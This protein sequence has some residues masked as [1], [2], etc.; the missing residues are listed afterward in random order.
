MSTV[1]GSLV[2]PVLVGREA[3][4]ESLDKALD[5]AIAGNAV[6]MIVGG[7]AGVGKSRLVNELGERAQAAGARV[8]VGACVE[9]GGEGI[10][11][12]PVV[13][14]LRA[15]A[16]EL[17]PDELDRVLG[18]GRAEVARL[19]PELG[20]GSAAPAVADSAPR[21]QELLLGAMTRLAAERP[22][23]LAFEDL[24]WADQSTF[25]LISLLVRGLSQRPVLLVYTVRSDELHRAHPFRR[26]AGR[27]EQQRV[28]E[29]IELERL[30]EEAVRSQI[31][32]IVGERPDGDLVER[33]FERSEGI[34]LFVEELVGAVRDGGVERDYLPPS[35]RDVLMAR[36]DVLSDEAQDVLR[37]VSAAGRWAPDAL[38]A[39]VM[40]MAEAQRYAALREILEHQLLI[41]DPSG[42]G[43]AF[44]HA[45]ARASIYEDL[46][47]GERAQLHKAFAEALEQD[48][49]LA[50]PEAGAAVM[51]A[52]HW[53]AAHDLPRALRA[54]VRAGHATAA[55]AGPGEAQRHFET[56][57]E[58]WSQVPEAEQRAGI[59]HGEL[60]SA[61]AQAAYYAGAVD[62]A[63]ALAD[64]GLAETGADE[65]SEQLARLL[66]QRAL[67]L[68]DLAGEHDSIDM[69]EQAEKQLPS[70]SPSPA[71]A[72][73]L[74]TLARALMRHDEMGRASE[75]AR[76]ALQHAEA[77]GAVAPESDARVTLGIAI[78]HNGEF[79]AG[80][81]LLREGIAQGRQAGLP[82]TQAR[83]YV[84]LSDAL[85]MVGRYEEAVIAADEGLAV[86]EQSGL[87]R[88]AGAFL[89]ANKAEALLRAGRWE[90]AAVD[91]APGIEA[92]G[93]FMAARTMLRAELHALSG[94]RREAQLDLR[95]AKDHLGR[96]TSAQFSLPIAWL[97]A[98]LHRAAGDLDR[99]RIS[100]RQGLAT[101][102][103]DAVDRYRWPLAWLGMR[104]EAQD[105]QAARSIGQPVPQEAQQRVRELSELTAQLIVRSPPDRCYRTL[106][107]AERARFANQDEVG[108]WR[109]AADAWR[110]VNEPFPLA[111][112]L[113]RQAS[114]LAADG[115][116]TE[117]QAPLSEA[118]RLAETM[119]AVPL[120]QEAHELAR[121]VGL[122]LDDGAPPPSA[123]DP[124]GLTSREQ[125]VLRLVAEGC[126]N[127]QI[128]ERLFISRKTASVHVS[129]ILSKLG[130]AS[131]TE[132]A[133]VAHRAGLA[134]S[135][136][137]A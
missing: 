85:M 82:W 97:D 33:V 53:L 57:L 119:G 26:L 80:T 36:L 65:D 77:A 56:A 43:Y 1:P 18:A 137:G 12:G 59:S 128:A 52:H 133:V 32:G 87:M 11:F 40:D 75:V 64:Q 79:E 94:R 88:G 107:E 37:V 134:N 120:A 115:R 20:D 69:L 24:Q 4:M 108:A 49:A 90:Q 48:S 73:L 27:W 131:R 50:G 72:D 110:E 106:V 71:S 68:T 3:E 7:E 5:Q 100:V 55:A 96:S 70:D 13:E 95:E 83:G 103:A 66:T 14:M 38:L 19:L 89:R 135:P 101:P 39:A 130:V 29:R 6:V 84:N 74:A 112:A 132:A 114:A 129:N 9:L 22:L 122:S 17:E 78:A 30:G 105:A 102:D 51:L 109:S 118:L 58:L 98:E 86:A 16:G 91:L 136:G 15:L 113:L 117:V 61:A 99:A 54:S 25:E 34:P 44:R 92:S 126:S 125:E 2:S 67:I 116:R 81:A 28:V 121:Q 60:L 42:G 8:L 104:I 127:G 62:R 63:L 41:V 10:P 45:L 124:H 46:L 111:Y 47:P 23:V 76:R 21:I 31:E 93:A 35:L 123:E